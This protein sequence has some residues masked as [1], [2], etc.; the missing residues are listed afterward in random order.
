MPSIKQLWQVTLP[1]ARVVRFEVVDYFEAFEYVS[2]NF[3]YAVAVESDFSITRDPSF[4]PPEVRKD[5]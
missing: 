4:N 1:D 2:T 5:V 3:G